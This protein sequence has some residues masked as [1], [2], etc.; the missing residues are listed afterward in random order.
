MGLAAALSGAALLSLGGVLQNGLRAIVLI[1]PCG[2]RAV[3]GTAP[4]HRTDARTLLDLGSSE[5]LSHSRILAGIGM[6]ALDGWQPFHLH[7]TLRDQPWFIA[8]LL[9]LTGYLSVSPLRA[10]RRLGAMT[11]VL[12]AAA[13]C[14]GSPWFLMHV[15]ADPLVVEMPLLQERRVPLTWISQ[16][17]VEGEF[18]AVS[19]AP[20]GRH[21]LLSGYADDECTRTRVSQSRDDTSWADSM[22]GHASCRRWTPPS[23]MAINC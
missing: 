10:A 6:I 11:G 5:P 4:S 13:I 2:W 18:S 3:A 1:L 8:S 12:A 17:T 23:S 7:V 21:F 14:V 19:L 9:A 16:S 22:A 20:D 15:A